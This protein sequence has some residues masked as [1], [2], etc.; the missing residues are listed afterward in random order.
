[1][2]HPIAGWLDVPH[3]RDKTELLRRIA[4][5]GALNDGVRDLAI[6]LVRNLR[7]D[8]HLERLARI[9]RFVSSL[10]YYREPVETFHDVWQTAQVGGDCDDRAALTGAL[11]WALRY[12]FHIVSEGDPNEPTH[13]YA[14]VGYPHADMPEGDGTTRW[15]ASETSV[16]AP[17]GAHWSHV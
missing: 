3:G 7:S 1:L 9:H 2:T 12:P 6:G 17:L 5:D 4:I 10:P 13:Y 11:A 15:V 16:P 14:I 8:D